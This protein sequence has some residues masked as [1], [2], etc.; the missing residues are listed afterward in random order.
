MEEIDKNQKSVQNATMA[1]ALITNFVNPFAVTALN[2]AVPHIGKE[3]NAS[4]T[5]LSWV[6]LSLLMVSALFALPFGR[7]ADIHG[8]KPVLKTGILLLVVTSTL[9]V[10][11]PNM[12]VFLLLRVLQGLS[13]A[14]VFATNIAIL[15]DVYPAEKR[16]SV[17]GVS[18]AAVYTG[19]SIGPVAGGMITHAFGWRGVFVA[20]AILALIAFIV[21]MARSPKEIIPENTKKLSPASVVLYIVSMGALLYGVV[22]LTQNI[23]SYILLAAGFVLVLLFIRHETR[24]EAPV[25]EVRLFKNNR[26]FVMSILAAVFNYAS[27]F[28]IGYLMSIYLQLARGMNAD[29]S[30]FIMISQPIVQ[31]VLSPVAGRL[32]DRKSPALI[33]SIGMAC[34]T[35]S[36]FMF[37]L[38]TETTPIPYIIAGFLITGTG[39]GFFTSPNS[40]V[41]YASVSHKD[42]GT[43]TALVSTSRNFGQVIG[44]AIL[45]IIINVVI[46]NTPIAAVAPEALVHNI[47]ISFTV[48]AAICFSGIF[49]SFQRRQARA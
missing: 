41:I 18:V 14:M 46:G 9:L 33:A 27:V 19:A 6:V 25:I 30:G 11:C 10:F 37:S 44:M 45:T 31:A 8:R 42:Y 2:I 43:A 20:I 28:A 22:T 15:I 47:K 35:C 38:L 13:C 1:V 4:A 5:A 40:N 34:C 32:S 48:F 7:F 23:W 39:I 3:F 17:L 16:G 24:T 49:I 29:I 26:V 12:T 36:L 21:A